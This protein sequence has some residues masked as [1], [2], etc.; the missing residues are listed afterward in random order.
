MPSPE[1]C[2]GVHMPFIRRSGPRSVALLA[3]GPEGPPTKEK[4]IV[5]LYRATVTA[6]LLASA[7]ALSA[8][9]SSGSNDNGSGTG[10]S[11]SSSSATACESGALT[12]EGSS[13]QKNA[14][15]DW[16]QKYQAKC[17]GATISYN[18]T[19]S[20]AGVTQFNGGQVDFGGS[21]SALKADKGEVDAAQKRC[22]STPVDL[23]MVT[24]PIT[25]AYNVKGISDLTL[26]PDVTTKIFQGKITSWDDAAIKALNPGASLPSTKITVF[27]R[28]DESGTTANFENWLSAAAP[29]LYTA[30]PSKTW[31]EKVGQGKQGSDGVQQGIKSVDGGVGY[32]E[33]SFAVSGGLGIAKIDNGGGAVELTPEAVGKAI[34]AATIKGTGDDLSLKLDYA[35][36]EAGAYPITGVTYE[37]VCTKYSDASVGKR[38]KA[39]LD[40]TSTDGQDG[41]TDL[42]YAPLPTDILTKVQAVVAKIS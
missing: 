40:Y 12:G 27:F 22:G 18:A 35:T 9:S 31:S 1:A 26:T 37:I 21:D 32:V 7:V 4:P 36:K 29:S 8:C 19:G 30:T 33:W 41:L 14:M 2:G 20:G 15:N 24:I 39:F 23:P 16:I 17:S 28:S 3:S 10:G 42:G 5:K 38:V 6:G 25:V 34:S 13:A 11:S